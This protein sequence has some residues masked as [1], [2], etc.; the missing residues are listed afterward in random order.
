MEDRQGDEQGHRAT[1][2]VKSIRAAEVESLI[3]GVTNEIAEIKRS[4]EHAAQ[5]R[6]RDTWDTPNAFSDPAAH[7]PTNFR[8]VIN[9]ITPAP[10][11]GRR[12]RPIVVVRQNDGIISVSAIDQAKK[13]GVG[14]VG[15]H[16]EGAVDER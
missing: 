14:A 4:A 12:S 3:Q 15:V 5:P 1:G 9:G 2:K 13:L 6:D 7:D 8:Y 16:L 10:T 11:T